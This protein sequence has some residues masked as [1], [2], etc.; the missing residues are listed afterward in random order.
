MNLTFLTGSRG[1]DFKNL[2]ETLLEWLYCLF[3]LLAT[4]TV[5]TRIFTA[6]WRKM[7]P[8]LQFPRN[9]YAPY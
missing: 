9:P 5:I 2:K 6:F 3:N 1:N 8:V 7:P 4:E